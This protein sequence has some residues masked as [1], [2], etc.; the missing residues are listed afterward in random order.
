[1]C[2]ADFLGSVERYQEIKCGVPQGS[3]LGQ[4]LFLIYIN[5]IDKVNNSCHSKLYADDTVL[6]TAHTN[7]ITAYN[8]VQSNLNRLAAWCEENQLAIHV[9]F[10]KVFNY[11]GVKL[12]DQINYEHFIKETAKLIA[13]KMYLFSKIRKYIN[14][15]QAIT[16]YKT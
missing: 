4:L 7:P 6:Y 13:H 8:Q 10:V 1:M 9:N 14:K 12:D 3:I 2:T 15:K 11:L 5:D 16:T